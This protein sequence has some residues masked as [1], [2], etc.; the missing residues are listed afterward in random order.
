VSAF[1]KQTLVAAAAKQ[2]CSLSELVLSALYENGS[3]DLVAVGEG[4]D[5]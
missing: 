5:G 2:G 4:R 3:L 1:E